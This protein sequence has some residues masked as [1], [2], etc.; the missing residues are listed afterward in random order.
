MEWVKR[1]LKQ[2][3]A[4]ADRCL[5]SAEENAE[6]D[7]PEKPD[8][9]PFLTGWYGK[10][11]ELTKRDLGKLIGRIEDYLEDEDAEAEHQGD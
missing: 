6:R 4:D 3:V 2:I 8:R 10:Q 1:S 7:C 5:T 11:L 9:Y